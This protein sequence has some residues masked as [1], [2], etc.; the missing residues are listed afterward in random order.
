MACLNYQITNG[1]AILPA[2]PIGLDCNLNPIPTIPPGGTITVCSNGTPGQVPGEFIIITILGDCPEPPCC[3][4]YALTNEGDPTNTNITIY[5]DC[6]GNPQSI[7][8]KIIYSTAT[9]FCAIPGTVVESPGLTI[10]Q[11]PDGPSTCGETCNICPT[12]TPSITPT[13]SQTPTPSPTKTASPTP[14][15]TLT[16]SITSSPTQTPTSTPT[17][18]ATPTNTKTPTQTPTQTKVNCGL[19]ITAQNYTYIDCCGIL[20]SGQG[21]G[22]QVILDY[23]RPYVGIT[24]LNSPTSQ[25]CATPTSTPT[26]TSTPTPTTTP[27]VTSTSTPTQTQ[28]PTKTPIPT[29]SPI[30][31]YENECEVFTLFDMGVSCNLIKSPTQ[32]AFNGILSVDVTGGTAPYSFYWNTGERTQT[33]SNIPFGTYTVL[34]VDYYGDYSA[35]TACSIL[36]P[37]PTSTP[38]Q[39]ITQTPSP[40]TPLPNL[41]LRFLGVSSNGS[42]PQLPLTFVPSGLQNGKPTWFNYSNGLTIVWNNSVTPNR[43][44]INSWSFGGTPI[45]SNQGTIPDTDWTFIGTPGTYSQIISI[46]GNCPSVLPL[47]FTYQTTPASC[48]GN[49]NGGLTVA[50]VG[51]IPP[52]TYSINGTTFQSSNIFNNLCASSFGLTVKDSTGTLAQQSITIAGNSNT[53]FTLAPTIIT[54]NAPVQTNPST[55]IVTWAINLSPTPPG[56]ITIVGDIIF[57]ITQIE[58]GPVSN[59]GPATTYSIVATNSLYLNNN[60]QTLVTTTPTTQSVLSTC[61]SALNTAT[62]ESYTERFVFNTN[63]NFTLT[64]QTISNLNILS[65]SLQNNCVSTARQTITLTLS[66]FRIL[67]NPCYT[68]QTSNLTLVDNHTYTPNISS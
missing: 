16:P 63:T 19:G 5:T 56:P 43:W 18:T 67:N 25:I 66:N 53:T 10:Q 29:C 33:I 24:L 38:T 23:T 1:S 36:A 65:P 34:V 41:C 68:I 7:V 59:S 35:T 22:Q 11:V 55:R 64:G 58:Q 61:N 50:P 12:P 6:F 49:C 54:T 21:A 27:V 3:L 13:Q 39:T 20:Q 28:T 46:R 51:G 17:N 26:S 30:Y 62:S 32:G 48:V 45:S 47:S 60:L 37:T 9:Y 15:P 52:Y 31:D 44:Q 42:V 40:T 14:T 4:C 2:T 8:N 57:N